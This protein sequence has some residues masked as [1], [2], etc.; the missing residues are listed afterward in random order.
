M[1]TIQYKNQAAL[2]LKLLPLVMTEEVF[3]LKG[4][5][6]INFFVRDYPRLSI[7]ID[8]TY[9]PI[10]ERTKSLFDINEKLKSIQL[11]IK[12]KFPSYVITERSD[13]I[14]KLLTGCTV[15]GNDVFIKLEVNTTIR[16][17]VL[18]VVTRKVVKRA[19][20]EFEV[21]FSVSTLSFEDLYGG[22]ICAALDRQHPRDLFDIKM[23]LENEGLTDELRKVFL[24]YLISSPRPISELLIPNE[25]TISTEWIN[26]FKGMTRIGV[27]LE[28]LY[29]TRTKLFHLVRESLTQ[30][31]KLFLLSFKEV[32]PE[33]NLIGLDGIENLPAVRWKL[34]NLSLMKKPK[35]DE[36]LLKLKKVLD[37]F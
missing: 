5:T 32:T 12:E 17:T 21:S 26:E 37:N 7:D 16:G 31:E 11:R 15:Y 4:G 20:A 28:E 6:A 33:W 2:L 29:H 3:S 18:P 24:V 22:K 9:L 23:L 19:A 8:L 34:H 13:K 25:L 30:N 36:A 10:E 14:S 27:T 1:D 35:H